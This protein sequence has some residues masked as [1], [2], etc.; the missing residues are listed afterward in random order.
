MMVQKQC[1]WW[2]ALKPMRCLVMTVEFLFKLVNR[3]CILKLLRS[4]GSTSNR[5]SFG[6]QG[7]ECRK[8]RAVLNECRES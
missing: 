2:L 6:I 1:E 8:F 5:L 4:Y 3:L 7:V